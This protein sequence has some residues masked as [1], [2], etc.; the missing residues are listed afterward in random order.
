MAQSALTVT[1]PNPTPPTNLSFVGNT[2]ALDS[3]RPAVDDGIPKA[4]PSATQTAGS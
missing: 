3:G 2:P 4:L 1:V